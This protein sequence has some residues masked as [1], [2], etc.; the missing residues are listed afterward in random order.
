MAAGAVS[1]RSS[2]EL[3]RPGVVS[4][5][6]LLRAAVA[7]AGSAS[8]LTAPPYIAGVRR[9]C[10][11]RDYSGRTEEEFGLGVSGMDYRGA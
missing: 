3:P 5:P 2:F 9:G 8:V 1:T 7:A 11:L 4:P 10:Y 6:A